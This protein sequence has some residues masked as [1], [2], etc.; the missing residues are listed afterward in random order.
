M[1]WRCFS[2]VLIQKKKKKKKN[3]NFI[4]GRL[5]NKI[6]DSSH[7]LPD[8]TARLEKSV[9]SFDLTGL[10]SQLQSE[11]KALNKTKQFESEYKLT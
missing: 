3:L 6:G 1:V 11:N 2:W 8:H 5:I 7:S 4:I 9:S 10:T